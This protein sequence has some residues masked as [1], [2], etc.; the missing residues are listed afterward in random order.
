[1]LERATVSRPKT[2]DGG[3]LLSLKAVDCGLLGPFGFLG[4]G[5]MSI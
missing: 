5:G 3:L 4:L 2:E 1:M